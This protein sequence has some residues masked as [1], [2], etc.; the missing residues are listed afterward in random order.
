MEMYLLK[1]FEVSGFP[2]KAECTGIVLTE[3]VSKSRH[4][5]RCRRPIPACAF[6]DTKP[7]TRLLVVPSGGE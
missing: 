1:G 7:G 6:H 3:L 5:C 2:S 4:T